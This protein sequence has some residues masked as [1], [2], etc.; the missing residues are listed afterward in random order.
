MDFDMGFDWT[1]LWQNM[2]FPWAVLIAVGVLLFG[3]LIA[4]FFDEVFEEREFWII[5]FVFLI[6][7]VGAAFA[8]GT[9]NPV[10]LLAATK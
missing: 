5:I 10:L 4:H 1:K 7:Y 3:L 9:L 8:V 6:V 2:P